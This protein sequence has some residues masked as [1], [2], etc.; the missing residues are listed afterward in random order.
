VGRES[1]TPPITRRAT[2]FLPGTDDAAHEATIVARSR[3]TS[4]Q[5]SLVWDEDA[6]LGGCCS[7][8]VPSGTPLLEL[9]ASVELDAVANP[10]GGLHRS[11][12]PVVADGVVSPAERVRFNFEHWVR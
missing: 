8:D 7:K 11:G 3:P 2:Y 6:A 9:R 1:S 5:V 10:I 12:A 4:G